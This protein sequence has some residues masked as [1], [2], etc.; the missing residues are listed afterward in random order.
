[1]RNTFRQEQLRRR[2][3]DFI[4]WCVRNMDTGKRF[5]LSRREAH[6]LCDEY[7]ANGV[8]HRIYPC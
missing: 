7:A 4:T 2:N 3:A 5:Y 8:W 1:M 6:K